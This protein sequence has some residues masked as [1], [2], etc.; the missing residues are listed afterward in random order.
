[1]VS[2]ELLPKLYNVLSQLP[3]VKDVVVFEDAHKGPVPALPEGAT[4]RL[5]LFEDV[6]KLG[7][8]SEVT[9]KS[10]LTKYTTLWNCPFQVEVTPPLAGDAAII[11]Y[12]VRSLP[13]ILIGIRAGLSNL[14]F[15]RAVP[16]GTPRASS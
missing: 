13:E 4:C 3:H 9:K 8:S 16:P 14:F 12:T 1:L 5:H 10:P 6:V 7:Q 11:M 2:Q 15:L